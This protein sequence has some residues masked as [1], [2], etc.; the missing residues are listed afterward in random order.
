MAKSSAR[1]NLIDFESAELRLQG[2]KVMLVV[3]GTKPYQNMKVS[4]K[5]EIFVQ[6][7]DWWPYRV[8]GTLPS[9]DL[10][11]TAPYTVQADVTKTLGKFGIEVV[12]KKK[13]KKLSIPKP[14]YQPAPA[15]VTR[16]LNE[17]SDDGNTSTSKRKKIEDK[18]KQHPHFT[19][20]QWLG[21]CYYCFFAGRWWKI[22]CM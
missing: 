22:G 13:R 4:L 10:P 18:A 16:L 7:P 1:G 14:K 12:G 20:C 11:M 17:V 2:R 21:P 9:I 15:H 19:R 3:K 6:Q 5:T 8:I